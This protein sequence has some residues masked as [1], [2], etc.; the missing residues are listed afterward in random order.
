MTSKNDTVLYLASASPRR[1]E[2]LQQIGVGF[3][4]RP[5]NIDET[6]LEGELPLD[7]VQRMAR[8]KAIATYEAMLSDGEIT[9]KDIAVLGSDTIVIDMNCDGASHEAVM[10]KP[11]DQVHAMDMLKRLSGT[12]HEVVTAVCVLTS[13]ANKAPEFFCD[14]GRAQVTFR[15]LDVS[16]IAA[17]WDTQEPVGKAGGYAIQGMGATFVTRIEGSYSAVVGLPL[18]ET[19]RLLQQAEVAIWHS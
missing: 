6:R 17:Y 8:E 9:D 2:L 10:G 5:A 4:T 14:T 11:E 16:T 7:F 12:T 15:A 18:F 3:T 13:R 1:S 19:A